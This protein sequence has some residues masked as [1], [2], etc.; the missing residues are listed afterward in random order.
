MPAAAETFFPVTDYDL[1]ATL[2]SGQVFRWRK[3]GDTWSGV[4]G[5]RRVWLRSREKGI[6]AQTDTPAGDWRWLVDYLQIDINLAG[7]LAGFPDDEPMRRAVAACR[8]LRLLRQ[9]PWECL[10]SFILS[11]TKRIAQ[12]QQI[13]ELLC[14][15]FGE[16]I[17]V[18]ERTFP[19]VQRIAA[20]SEAELR[21]CKTG[22]R[23]PYL[24]ATARQV[25]EGK[26]CDCCRLM[27]PV[28]NSCDCLAWDRRLPIA[29]CCSPT[30]F[31]QRSRWMCG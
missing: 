17:S 14:E 19:K 3:E 10:A 13:V 12:I 9:D 23:A 26:S 27:R 1:D 25:A 24:L 2:A 6:I 28:R 22:F 30:G 4:V 18:A 5:T 29:C 11:S 15:R 21:A 31:P 7:V 8:G 16:P 20:A